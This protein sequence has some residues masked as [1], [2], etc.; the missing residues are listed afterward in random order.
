M[1]LGG[2]DVP[3]EVMTSIL[4][5]PADWRISHIYSAVDSYTL[6]EEEGRKF[7]AI[8]AGSMTL[9]SATNLT[10]DTEVTIQFRF[11][12]T[13]GKAS[14]FSI[15][16][17][18]KSPGVLT[19]N[20]MGVGLQV[21]AGAEQ[22][23]A[24]VNLSAL[25][26]DPNGFSAAYMVK[27]LPK[28]RQS[29]PDMVR[30]R[31]EQDAETV[32]ALS[33]RWLTVRYVLR[34]DRALVYLDG[35]ML[36][37][38]GGIGIDPE[39]YFHMRLYPDVQLASV[40]VCKAPREDPR[41]EPVGIDPY[42]NARL[43]KGDS[44][45]RNSLPAPG[46][47]RSIKG[48][49]FVFPAVDARGNDHVAVNRSWARF[50]LV[51]GAHDGWEG[52]TARWRGAL[53]IRP[54]RIQFRIPNRQYT[55]LHLIAAADG[56]PDTVPIVTAQFYRPNAG[57]PVNFEARVPLFTARSS[58]AHRLPVR[59]G[60]GGEGDLYLVTIPLEPEGL[61]SVADLPY[62]EFELTKQVTIYRAFP[63]PCYYSM[64]QA[65]RPSGVH[66][67]AL[68]LEKAR[69]EVEFEPENYAHIWTAPEIPWYTIGLVNRGDATETVHIELATTSLDGEDATRQ[70]QKVRISAGERQEL[71][72]RLDLEKYGYHKVQLRV[73]D[74]RGVRTQTRSLAHLHP[75]TR[76]RGGW[77][78][79]TGPL[80]GFWDWG[81]GHVTPGGIPRLE[82]MVK[83]G[84]ESSNRPLVEGR[85]PKEE[86]AYAARHGM[87][88]HFLAYQLHM[89]KEHLGGVEWD[90]TK[91]DE[92]RKAVI[93]AVRKSPM[94]TATALNKPELAVF[95]GEPLLGP[96]SYTSLP[97]FYGEPA[98]EMTPA[99]WTAYSNYLSQIVIAG[100]AI[101]QTWPNAKCLIPW[102][103]PSFPI[104][105]LRHSKE[106]TAVM[107]GPAIDLILFERLPEMQ[108]HQ[109]T[110]PSTMWQ[111][112]QE[113]KKTGKPWPK[114]TTVEGHCTSPAL[115]GALTMQQEADHFIRGTF[116]LGA[117]G[118]TRFLGM[119]TPFQCAGAWGE[120]HY[121]GGM[122]ERIPLLSPKIVYSAYAT[123]T[124]QL[125]R[126]NFVKM[127]PTGSLTVFSCQYEHYETGELLH[128]FWTLRGTRPVMLDVP[129]GGQIAVYDQMDNDTT[130][131]ERDGKVEIS[132]DTSPRYVWGLADGAGIALGD[133]DH[134]DS[135]PGSL[136]EVLPGPAD[137]NWQLSGEPDE[138]YENSH[139][140]FV[141]RYLG[142]MSV[143]QVA[144]P[145][146]QGSHALAIHLEKQEKDPKVMPFYTTLAPSKP[147]TIPGKASHLGLW[148]RAASDW[149]RMVYCLRDA[150]GERWISV[151]KTGEWNVD[152]VHCWSAF[153]FD[154]WR[155]LT[156]E[157]PGN[158][159]Y[160]CF[161]E[162]GTS[163][164]GYYGQ[165][166]KIVD[167]PLQIEKIIVE[168]RTHVIHGTEALPASTDDVLLGD[169]YAEYAAPQD[170]T[171][172]AVRLSR[173]RMPVSGTAP[174]LA[175][176]IAEL[177]QAGTLPPTR[178][179]KVTPPEHQ[180]DGR[181][182]HVHFEPVPGA[183]SYDVW[184]AP[185]PDGRGAV[186]LGQDWTES[187]KLLTGLSANTDQYLFVV[188][189]DANGKP[190]KPSSAFKINLKDM[191]PM[192]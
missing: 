170:K 96:V 105:F 187:G 2:P 181:R 121:G 41:F 144:A 190:S 87:V 164:W 71:K 77:E 27:R 157:M 142:K 145:K 171:E 95:F 60:K 129:S 148:V 158:A 85:Y 101:K 98:Y 160:D 46:T 45:E 56:E 113:W 114:L 139:R 110:Y 58:E 40:R 180:Y 108:L 104:P 182:C 185:H 153:C 91:P 116:L 5:S 93:D 175:N 55:H 161:R 130:L 74:S 169:L 37:E 72:F 38:A 14:T 92:M 82:V 15:Y 107:D 28:S 128:I 43:I 168:R 9:T 36:R 76:E 63:D 17:G 151:G 103:I 53:D 137:G 102:G 67:Y 32:S 133:P 191:F 165:G 97:E 23:Y 132:V 30:M 123:M 48:V 20:P 189:A 47:P 138:D 134:A 84:A 57:F 19:P 131:R 4:G 159:P 10:A 73:E 126:M 68:T 172:E 16:A 124:R 178:L 88:T 11:V 100:T 127:V 33:N 34:K 106:A 69:V 150:K 62:L 42:L 177:L 1:A 29:W 70:K 81:G 109:V 163:F 176:P 24:Y 155:Y 22:N 13:G 118:T 64:H 188:Y 75:D 140:E 6:K 65:G 119:P 3:A 25:P 31:V 179:L 147:V 152:D 112:Q 86:L 141:R 12:P 7:L 51:E 8:G 54:G 66:V 120:Q 166:D 89:I 90:P 26:G 156:F 173:L 94:A 35:R 192:K 136:A 122:C 52:D 50:G 154:G 146:R 80:F 135:V 61:A 115:P 39:G 21:P 186:L 78:E 184:M 149:G 59:L 143:R 83:A 111:L 117:Y 167:L 125:N 99:E 18:L 79:G 174:V 44:V 49:P 162:K 183:R